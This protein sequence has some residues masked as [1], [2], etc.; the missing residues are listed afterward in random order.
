MAVHLALVLARPD[1]PRVPGP[2]LQQVVERFGYAQLLHQAGHN[3]PDLSRNPNSKLAVIKRMIEEIVRNRR[4][5]EFLVVENDV[6]KKLITVKEK[7]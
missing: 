1:R 5:I 4:Q 2:F 7:P 3:M 6:L